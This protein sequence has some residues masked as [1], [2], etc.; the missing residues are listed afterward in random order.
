[1]IFYKQSEISDT[2]KNI[3]KKRY[4][5]DGETSWEDIT[6]RVNNFVMSDESETDKE[7]S[8]QM[9]LNRYFIPN[10]P[11]L[12][13]AGKPGGGLSACYVV[14]FKDTIEDIYKTK[15]DFALIARKGGG[16]GTTLSKLRPEDSP[17][18][19]STHG[20]AGGPI[21][22]AD[23]ISHDM[24]ALSQGGFREMAIMFT[25]DIHHP[26]IEKFITAKTTEGKISNANISVV[27]N[28]AFMKAVENDWMCGRAFG[29]MPY[30]MFKARDTFNLIVDEAWKNG[31]PGLIFYDRVND[32]PYRY[33][34]QE[35][36]ATNPC[37]EQGLPLNGVCNLGSL[38][39]TKFL[40]DD[41][42]INLEPLELAVRLSI[43]FLD[44]VVSKNSYPTPEITKWSD[45]NRA[46]G[47]GIMGLADSYMLRGVAYGSKRALEELSFILS[48]IKNIAEDESISISKIMGIPESCKNLPVPRRN[49]TLLS[50]AP[51]GT[52]SILAGSNSGIEPY[53]SD[54]IARTDKT[55]SYE[56]D[57]SKLAE[58]DYF[59][60]AVSANGATEVTWK[61]HIDTLATCQKFIDSGVSKTI[62]FPKRTNR[63]TIYEAFI[64]AWKSGVKGLTVYR[65]QSRS[66]EVLTPQEIKKNHCP[67]CKSELIKESACTKCSNPECG[68]SLCEVG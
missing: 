36:L 41:K 21:R 20:F 33:S 39:I 61:E 44:N 1:M 26:D 32:S 47:L 14:D 52:I 31:E 43:K 50:L 25:L 65:N 28:D 15:L 62:N 22:F 34:N 5:W 8:R 66:Q 40:N 37:G 7:L 3:L 49:V 59:R 57:H 63:D 38:D 29:S 42:S 17:V 4:L 46:I 9:M 48:F 19:G 16:C 10:S 68:F 51:T 6:N 2:A 11:C 45:D 53:F 58:E 64:Y 24:K 35:I 12:V 67:L 55:G 56:F 27:V 30:G 54:I 13:N 60:C 23:T 18:H